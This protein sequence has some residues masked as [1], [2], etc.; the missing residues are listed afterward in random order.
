LD[1]VGVDFGA[2]GGGNRC[3]E[4]GETEE[5]ILIDEK[6]DRRALL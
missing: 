5:E 6:V 1:E 2:E 3:D 4:G